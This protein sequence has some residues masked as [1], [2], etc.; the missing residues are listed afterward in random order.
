M[1]DD[2]TIV[3]LSTL[4][5]NSLHM[6]ETF[7]EDYMQWR[8]PPS[9]FLG[10]AGKRAKIVETST[11]LSLCA[12]EWARKVSIICMFMMLIYSAGGAFLKVGG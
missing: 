8:Q 9:T 10:G 6:D 5:V 11:V 2:A 4:T 7:N 12:A 1:M 3:L